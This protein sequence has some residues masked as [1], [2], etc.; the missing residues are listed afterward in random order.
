MDLTIFIITFNRP[1]FINLLLSFVIKKNYDSNVIVIDGSE[2]K[3]KKKN[4][5]TIK[6]IKQS[7]KIE[8][9]KIKYFHS[10]NQLKIIYKLAKSVK[11]KF[12]LFTY[13][14]DIPGK[15]FIKQSLKFLN[16]NKDYVTTNG[17]FGTSNISFEKKKIRLS[18]IKF[19]NMERNDIIQS[20]I[21]KRFLNF[22]YNEGFAYGVYRKQDFINIFKIV[23]ILCDSIK[24]PIKKI[25]HVV[26]HK[27]MTITFAT[28]NLLKGKIKKLDKIMMIRINHQYNQTSSINY[29]DRI[30]GWHIMDFHRNNSLYIEILVKQLNK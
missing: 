8:N 2:P 17:F 20:T 19:S 26:S 30:G 11:T 21:Q 7:Y 28:Y 25:E 22:N 6:K 3:F 10:T 4:Q 9:E 23:K 16:S 27:L 13:D 5:K 18:N 24:D 14:D 29:F 12:C 15:D 1:Q